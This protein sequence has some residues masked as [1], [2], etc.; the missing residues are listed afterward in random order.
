MTMFET[1][2]QNIPGMLLLIDFEKAFDSVS[3]KFIHNILDV[4][5]FGDSIKKWIQLFQNNTESCVI[6]NGYFSSF[7]KLGRGCRQGD[8]ISPYIFILCVEILGIAIRTN[9]N[10]KGITLWNTM[11][12]IAQYA[13]DTSLLLDGSEKSLREALN[14]F[15]WYYKIS[16][17]KINTD[18]TKVVWLGSMRESDRRFCRENNLKWTTTFKMLGVDFNAT[19]LHTITE[20]KLNQKIQKMK[21]LLK[22]WSMHNIT[23]L[24]KITVIKSLVLPQITHL[25]ISL[26][27]P[28]NNIIKELDKMFT[29][30]IWNNKVPKINKRQLS[31]GYED[32]GLKM[33]DL[34]VYISSLKLSWVRRYCQRRDAW[35]IF[36]EQYGM[37]KLLTV[38]P[39]AHANCPIVK[40][41]FWSDVR[42][43]WEKFSKTFE[44]TDVMGMLN[45]PI[46]GNP[47]IKFEYINSWYNKGILFLRDIIN[48]ESGCLKTMHELKVDYMINITFLD[49]LRLKR[50]VPK[51]W[52]NTIE[53]KFIKNFHCILP[54]LSAILSVEKGCSKY[55]KILSE[56]NEVIPSSQVKWN[57][58]LK[59]IDDEDNNMYFWK[60]IYKLPFNVTLD[61]KLRYFQHKILK[62]IL[63]TNK[64]LVM[65]KIKDNNAC[66]F[67]GSYVESIVH[68]FVECECL[69]SLWSDL[70]QWLVFCGYIN[71]QILEPT[72]IIL[73]KLDEDII[74]NFTI[75][76]A[77]F[78]IYRS[79]LSD[80]RPTFAAVKAYLRYVMGIEKYIAVTNSTMDKFYGKWTS[81]L[82]KL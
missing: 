38:G 63:P 78:V 8:P 66:S 42:V 4:F 18:K 23:P 32:G 82:H 41:P 11:F 53:N 62:R 12:K 49:Y 45:Q 71:L 51:V 72:D 76:I 48:T 19:N 68:L 22:L 73:G 34:N 64:Y 35:N 58:E 21:N 50:A 27:N 25:L 81:I 46:W 10:I 20:K 75:L 30:F 57:Q 65:V 59:L 2:K 17:L 60:K 44:P 16:G 69:V 55:T 33:I 80:K 36:P 13:D 40:N 31:R 9:K 47:N 15:D 3:W 5:N 77:K 24:G 70:R 67:C 43:A 26:P 52:L 28:D 6:Q 39:L 37:N 79:K 56:I 1:E 7:F 14:T 74:F 29:A 54:Q 61:A